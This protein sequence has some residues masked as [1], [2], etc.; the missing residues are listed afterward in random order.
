SSADL[1][2]TN[3]TSAS[4]RRPVSSAWPVPCAMTFTVIPV[5]FLN[6][7]KRYSN[8]PES[9]VDVVDATTIDLSCANDCGAVKVSAQSASTEQKVRRDS[10]ENPPFVSELNQ[11]I[12]G[13]E[14]SCFFGLRVG[15]EVVGGS[16]FNHVTAVKQNDL[17]TDA[18]RL[19]EVMRGHDDFHA[20]RRNR[21]DDV[22]DCL[23]CC[24]VEAG[25]RLVE[26]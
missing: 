19:P 16:S 9:C 24:R 7:G 8:R 10:I 26:E 5:F 17:A 1:A 12:A 4:P 25:G 21:R 22:F 14:F 20:A 15:E 6:S 11:Q 13:D 18:P 23:G 2:C 3:T